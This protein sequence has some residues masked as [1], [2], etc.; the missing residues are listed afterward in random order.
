LHLAPQATAALLGPVD[1]ALSDLR[2]RVEHYLARVSLASPLDEAMLRDAAATLQHAADR[3]AKA[4]SANGD[5]ATG[6]T[7]E[8]RPRVLITGA[9]GRIGSDLA[10]R[11]VDRY[12]LRLMYHRSV[13]ADPPVADWVTADIGTVDDLRSA[14]EGMDAV[15]HLAGEPSPKASWE[16]VLDANIVGAR[17][18]FE[19]ARLTGVGRV[20]FASTNHVMGMYDRDGAWP[21]YAGQP[22]RPDSLY[23]VSKAFGEAL[24]RFYADQYGMRVVCLRIGWWLPEPTDAIANWMWLSPRDGA[25]IVHRALEAEVRFGVYYAVSA[26]AGR[27]WDIADAMEQLGYRPE[28]DAAR[29]RSAVEST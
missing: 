24:G 29:R 12:E 14:M 21:I 3:L 8:H 27:H 23:G 4:A 19:A 6:P 26:N 11:L 2:K 25:H 22:V 16:E 1:D 20:V 10:A 5:A 18:V 28:D 17:N 15:V 13:P 9:G 7:P